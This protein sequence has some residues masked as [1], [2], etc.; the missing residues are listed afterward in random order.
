MTG[1]Y[2]LTDRFVVSLQEPGPSA[3]RF[4]PTDCSPIQ[5]LSYLLNRLIHQIEGISSHPRHHVDH[6]RV[7]LGPLL[8]GVIRNS[9]VNSAEKLSIPAVPPLMA[10][11]PYFITL[12]QYASQRGRY[13]LLDSP[14][15]F[16]GMA[17]V[18]V[19]PVSS[20][21]FYFHSHAAA[22]IADGEAHRYRVDG[23]G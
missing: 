16:N 9:T 14:I 13:A 23:S 18:E 5:R 22:I 3:P 1:L 8:P 11:A 6:L 19:L 20:L 7:G 15:R 12:L 21:E 2:F 17:V 4:L 10:I